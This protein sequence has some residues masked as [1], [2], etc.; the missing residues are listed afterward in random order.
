M[1]TTTHR[2]TVGR[3]VAAAVAVLVLSACEATGPAAGPT[4]TASVPATTVPATTVPATT[5]PATTV[6]ATTVPAPSPTT[7]TAPTPGW[8]TGSGEFGGVVRTWAI[9]VPQV[10][11]PGPVPLVVALHGGLGSAERFRR[12][13]RLDALAEQEGFIV[14]FPEA[15]E[16]PMVTVGDRQTQERS[17]NAVGCC[18][19]APRRGVDDIGFVTGLV[20]QLAAT[21]PVDRSRV[22]LLGSSNG[23]MLTA[24]IACRAAG[25]AA[26]YVVN[27]AATMDPQCAPGQPVNLLSLHGDADGNVPIDGG[28]PSAGLQRSMVYPSLPDSLAPFLAAGACD[29][30]SSGRDEQSQVTTQQWTCTEGAEV[31]SMV[32][33]GGGHGWPGAP[34]SALGQARP[35]N[36]DATAVAWEFLRRHVGDAG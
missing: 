35:D 29:A 20:D 14:L 23:G 10:L 7:T 28:R 2:G 27:A 1:S 21:L 30:A 9:H 33:H 4:T 17:W 12:D 34:R 19:S 8:R 22:Y 16:G 32:L 25:F 36:L 13:T 11:P 26:A 5:V 18:G 24:A 3:V 31:V 6:P 15:V